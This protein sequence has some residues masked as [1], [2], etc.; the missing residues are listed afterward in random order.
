M[1]QLQLPA[2][3]PSCEPRAAGPFARLRRASFGKTPRSPESGGKPLAWPDP[4]GASC[5]ARPRLGYATQATPLTLRATSTSRGR[6]DGSASV[7]RR[8][9]SPCSLT[10]RDATLAARALRRSAPF[11]QRVKLALGREAGRLPL[12]LEPLGDVEHPLA[13]RLGLPLAGEAR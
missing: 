12:E 4:R 13:Q 8:L 11:A 6:G 1:P 9:T 5:P 2:S 10:S 3:G 7:R